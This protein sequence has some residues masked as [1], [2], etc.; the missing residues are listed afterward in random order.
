MSG[1]EPANLSHSMV[2][3]IGVLK[4]LSKNIKCELLYKCPVVFSTNHH[5]LWF[6]NSN[7]LQKC[8]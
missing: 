3:F 7:T 5:D 4:I 2:E 8:F 1:Q 6:L